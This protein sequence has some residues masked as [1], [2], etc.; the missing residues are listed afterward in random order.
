MKYAQ[1]VVAAC[2]ASQSLFFASSSPPFLLSTVPSYY[3]FLSSPRRLSLWNCFSLLLFHVFSPLP[4][5]Q[6]LLV[7]HPPSLLSLFTSFSLST[8]EIS[9]FFFEAHQKHTQRTS[10]EHKQT[11]PN[12]SFKSFIFGMPVFPGKQK[13]KKIWHMESNVKSIFFS[14]SFW[15]IS[16]FSHVAHTTV[17]R[18]TLLKQCWHREHESP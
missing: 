14:L 12:T 18:I 1:P 7:C 15:Y 5:A 11:S 16:L 8:T 6:K 9:F 17:A 10:Y 13:Q 2:L 4:F 3:L